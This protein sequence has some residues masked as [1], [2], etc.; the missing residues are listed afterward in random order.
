MIQIYRKLPTGDIGWY[1]YYKVKKVKNE[2]YSYSYNC[3]DIFADLLFPALESAVKTDHIYCL[4]ETTSKYFELL[5]EIEDITDLVE[6]YPEYFI[7]FK[8]IN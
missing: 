6:L 5:C 4:N 8:Y 7:W 2:M 3:V 1:K